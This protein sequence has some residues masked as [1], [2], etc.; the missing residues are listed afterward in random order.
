MAW[1]IPGG[2][3]ATAVAGRALCLGQEKKSR[4]AREGG[5]RPAG[6]TT[7]A[8][9]GVRPDNARRPFLLFGC[10]RRYR[11]H[12]IVSSK[13]PHEPGTMVGRGTVIHAWRPSPAVSSDDRGAAVGCFARSKRLGSF[14]LLDQPKHSCVPKRR[15]KKKRTLCSTCSRLLSARA[16]RASM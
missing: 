7:T 14:A 12:P 1:G 15:Q 2:Q 10:R 8:P 5:D 13:R 16:G 9:P 11:R 4:E 6:R 3:P